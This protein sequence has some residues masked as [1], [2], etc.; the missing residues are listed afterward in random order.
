ML[1]RF[2]LVKVGAQ[3]GTRKTSLIFLRI[4]LVIPISG[5]IGSKDDDLDAMVGV[6]CAGA[7]FTC[8]RSSGQLADMLTKVAFICNCGNGRSPM[9]VDTFSSID[10][11]RFKV[12]DWAHPRTKSASQ[13]CGTNYSSNVLEFVCILCNQLSLEGM[14]IINFQMRTTNRKFLWVV[15]IE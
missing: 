15:H 7:F 3:G 8:V 10:G 14:N 12:W 5:L 4:F 2:I 9:N 11:Y 6:A 13:G 1:T